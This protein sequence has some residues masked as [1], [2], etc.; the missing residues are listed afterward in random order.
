MKPPQKSA[1]AILR[2]VIA[3][4]IAIG[5][6]KA[7]LLQEIKETGS[8]A[9][10]GRSMGMSYKRA[11]YLVDT[12]NRHF[13]TPLVKSAKGGRS[14]GGAQLTALGEDVLAAFR[15]MEVAA[16]AAIA[17]IAKRLRRKMPST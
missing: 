5:P 13:G 8:I 9:A 3:P 12:L 7:A 11:W 15:D 1:G 6:G 2:V 4:G 14:G 16:D 17:P 10:A